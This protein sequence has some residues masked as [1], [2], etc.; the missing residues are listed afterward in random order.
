M[1]RP[2]GIS[3]HFLS[4]DLGEFQVTELSY[5]SSFLPAEGASPPTAHRPP[6]LPSEA[7]HDSTTVG[8]FS[9]PQ[10]MP[11]PVT[12]VVTGGPH[13]TRELQPEVREGRLEVALQN[14]PQNSQSQPV[15][16]LT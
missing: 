2:P 5:L 12:G 7:A 8:G 16:I 9:D 11:A 4:A 1:K 13:S 15:W 10:E 14:A 6:F 3:A